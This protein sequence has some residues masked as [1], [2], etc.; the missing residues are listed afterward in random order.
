VDGVDRAVTVV[1]GAAGEERRRRAS[2][3]AL[4]SDSCG[5]LSRG[6]VEPKAIARKHDLTAVCERTRE[7]N[8]GEVHRA[9]H[10]ACIARDGGAA[11]R[12][13]SGH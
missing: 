1:W 6:P 8:A 3:N 4:E 11:V 13:A 2:A 7:A 5:P 12:T 9:A 10:G